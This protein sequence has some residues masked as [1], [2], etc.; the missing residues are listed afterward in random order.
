MSNLANIIK[1]KRSS[2]ANK[3]STLYSGELAYS[4]GTTPGTSPERL[5]FGSGDDGN[6]NATRIDNIGGLYYTRLI[7]ASSAGTLTTNAKS[8]P[9]LDQY[10]KIN[11]WLVGNLELT[12]NT[13][14]TTNGNLNVILSANGTGKVQI[15]TSSN[16]F[17]LPSSRTSVNGYVL[18]ANTDGTTS[19]AQAS[20]SVSLKAGTGTGDS[21][22][23][24]TFSLI[25]DDIEFRGDA[26]AITT[27]LSVTSGGGHNHY[28]VTTSARLASTS[29]TGV[30]SFNSS[31]FSVSAGGEVTVSS[32]GISNTQLVNSTLYI[33][34][35]QVTLGDA[36]GT[37]SSLGVDITGKATTAGTADQVAYSLSN[38]NNIQSFSYDGSGTATVAL[39]TTLT[40]VDSISSSAGTGSVTLNASG[41]H[42]WTF[43]TDGTTT[44]NSAYT[45]PA[46]D[47]S[48]GYV[49]T[50]DGTGTVTWEQASSSLG[51]SGD[52]GTGTIDLLT[53]SLTIAGS[54]AISTSAGSQTLTVSVATADNSTLGVASFDSTNFTV[55]SGAVSITASSISNSQLVNSSFY[56][57]T[58]NITLGDASGATPSLAVDISGKATTAGTADKVAHALSNGANIQMFTFDGSSTA[59][60][61]LATTLTDLTEVDVGNLKIA[62]NDISAKTG[63]GA[64]SVIINSTGSDGS[65]TYGWTFGS[66]GNLE[67]AG[68]ITN[69]TDPTSPQ[70]AA[71]K[72]Y[73]DATASGLKIH[74][75]VVVAT[76]AALSTIG[77]TVAYVDGPGT[78]GDPASV[79]ATLTFTTPITALD[80][81]SFTGGERILVKDQASKKQNGVYVY[82]S[83][84]TWTR[85]TDF[86][87]AEKITGADFMF[88]EDGLINGSTGWVQTD[89][90]ITSI[91]AS[92]SNISFV[93][94]SAA[95]SYLAGDGINITGNT[96]AVKLGTYS[97]LSTSGGSLVISGIAGTAATTGL[98]YT[99]GVLQIGTDG[100]SID[101]NGS[102][103]LE[104][105]STWAGQTAITTVG[106]ITTGT[107]HGDTI[108]YAYGGTGQTSYAKGDIIYASATNT[109]SKLT[110]G[111]DGMVLQQ[112]GGVPTWGYM[113][114][115]TY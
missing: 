71:T 113:D 5:F 68:K 35:T 23:D 52:S 86:D 103:N 96:I 44:F 111:T 60:V 39:A 94:F 104:I 31:T 93:Q 85:A 16:S 17:T 83:S 1:I 114:G 27:A 66:D 55:T 2:T 15:N 108:T 20:S 50:T 33:G 88:V 90:S 46:A 69:V 100:T 101:I 67:V 29:V 95:N 7:D 91:G 34:T 24:A 87:H 14:S 65:T 115:G 105:K 110:A 79:G 12:G 97:G 10:G 25:N 63:S 77:G 42:S 9:I 62:T 56:I 107:W 48:A 45:L 72:A 89:Q 19:W 75:P 58:T 78:G 59:S 4:Y 54:G 6:G 112:Q 80:G 53:Q 41:G 73:V 92:G 57:G 38:G 61:A 51:I 26:K 47:G 74:D 64:Q 37:T 8:I 106:T 13:L 70:D 28:V 22:T 43:N 102:G 3:P 109:L 98:T 81:Y 40:D 99:N 36:S 21:G 30:A 18:T 84:T 82:T 11:D 49:L 32:S 76:T